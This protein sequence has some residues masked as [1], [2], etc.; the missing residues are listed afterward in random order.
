M[1]PDKDMIQALGKTQ[2]VVPLV[3]GND[4][5]STFIYTPTCNCVELDGHDCCGSKCLPNCV[6]ACERRNPLHRCSRKQYVFLDL[7]QPGMPIEEAAHKAG[8]T[9]EAAERF[10][11]KPETV[12]WLLD[13]E[14]KNAT[15]QKWKNGVR[16]WEMGDEVLEGKR[17]LAKDQQVVYLEFGKRVCPESKSN[18]E[19]K[20]TTINFNF[21][22]EAVK[23]AFR[24]QASIEA[25]IMEK[26]S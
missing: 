19:S 9:T 3:V 7:Y 16:W 22:P 13:Q 21:S 18:P 11:A 15:A 6:C 20:G 4:V 25:E 26:A 23:E 12:R 5:Y 1:Q 2:P 8:L 14:R 24:R 10:L 17:H